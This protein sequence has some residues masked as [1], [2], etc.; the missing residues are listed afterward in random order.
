MGSN[1]IILSK[2]SS[3]K[4]CF[5]LKSN[6]YMYTN[7]CI[8]MA[9]IRLT[10]NDL[11]RIVRNVVN[12][13]LLRENVEAGVPGHDKYYFRCGWDSSYGGSNP[14]TAEGPIGGNFETLLEQMQE[15]VDGKLQQYEER[16]G[17]SQ[18]ALDA[19]LA[20]AQSRH[21]SFSPRTQK[22]HELQMR[23]R[24]QQRGTSYPEYLHPGG[25]DES[26]YDRY[27]KAIETEVERQQEVA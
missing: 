19:Y 27:A 20:N 26:M 11:K 17:R 3:L 23:M 10:E 7:A 15:Y 24:N 25:H 14:F 18:K 6:I 13:V 1:P 22:N 12:E 5:L 9:R 16:K 2:I 8:I 21:G 4:Y